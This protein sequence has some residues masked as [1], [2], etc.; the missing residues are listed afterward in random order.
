M[1]APR[2]K[3]YYNYSMVDLKSINSHDLWY[4]I[5]YIA[6]DGNLSS[7]N[8]HINITSKDKGHLIKI[9]YSLHVKNKIG[10]K[11]RGGEKEKKYFYLTF[12]DVK[13]YRYL[14]STGLT[15]RKSC[16]LG[17]MIIPKKFFSDFLRGVIDG[18]GSI[19]TWTNNH[20]HLIQWSIRIT[21]AAPNFI[22]WLKAEIEALILVKGKLYSY[23][24]PNKNPIY[25]LK[26]GK[27]PSKIIINNIYKNPKCLRLE[28]KFRQAKKCLQDKNKMINYSGVIGPGAVTGS[29]DRLKIC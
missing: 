2:E 16:T 27:L 18:D 22:N 28:R 24:Y 4:V 21:S 9:K 19:S 11:A 15:Q 26:F 29:Q 10:A 1:I 3:V 20:N 12:G 7:D 8:R 14:L 13:F 5:G 6:T 17:K 25:I 23:S